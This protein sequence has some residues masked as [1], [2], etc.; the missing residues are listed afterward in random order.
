MVPSAV[1][2]T[3]TKSKVHTRQ[4]DLYMEHGA[5]NTVSHDGW[6]TGAG[7]SLQQ[8]HDLSFREKG[9]VLQTVSKHHAQGMPSP[10]EAGCGGG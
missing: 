7:G 3:E 6:G 4:E 9:R 5:E 2:N 8:S 1:G 10:G